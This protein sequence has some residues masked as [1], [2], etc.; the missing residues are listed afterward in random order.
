MA[1]LAAT[2]RQRSPGRGPR[3]RRAPR[4]GQ[5]GSLVVAALL[6]ALAVLGGCASQAKLREAD[7]AELLAA[8]PGHYE[9]ATQQL[10][11][12]VV[13]VYTPRLGHYVLYSRESAANDPGRIMSQKMLS[14]SIDDKR[15]IVATVYTFVDPLR[16]RGGLESP[17]IFTVVMKD[18]LKRV[19]GCELLWKKSPGRFTG[20]ADPEHCLSAAS[21]QPTLA[22]TADSLTAGG[23]ELRR[24]R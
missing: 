9:N 5:V 3:A 16:W 20:A 4:A 1:E 13:H 12:D 22:V 19:P 23:L 6:S 10:A 21:S 14:F 7:M 18:D 8:L 2:G 11:F 24:V 15:G 17:D